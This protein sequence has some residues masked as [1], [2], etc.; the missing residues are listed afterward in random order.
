MFKVY[1]E[2]E[3]DRKRKLH[4]SGAEF[5]DAW[6]IIPRGLVSLY[7]WMLYKTIDWYMQLAP[8]MLDDC[9]IDKLGE[10][11]LI[12]APNTA[13]SILLSTI[14]GAGAAIFGLYS[15]SGR[16]WSEGVVNWRTGTKIQQ[17]QSVGSPR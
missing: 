7:C 2:S 5:L 13:H 12:D 9:N 6:R 16:K 3:I 10:K 11:C 14:V 1:E 15:N 8:Y 17:S 4:L